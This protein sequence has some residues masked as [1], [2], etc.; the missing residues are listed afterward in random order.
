MHKRYI[1]LLFFLLTLFVVL[2]P[3]TNAQSVRFP[4]P[5]L[6]YCE[7]PISCYRYCE[8]PQNT[9]TCWSYGKYVLKRNV[10]GEETESP[11]QRAK[12]AGITFPVAELGGCE[13]AKACMSY[14]NVPEHFETCSQFAQKHGL[15]K[16]EEG[17][18]TPNPQV[19]QAATQ[20]LGCTSAA[21]CKATCTKQE[22]RT[23]CAEFAEK[24][25]LAKP[26]G[27]ATQSIIAKAKVELGCSS[28]TS[29]RTLCANPENQEK[30]MAFGQKVALIDKEK[31]QK[32]Q[33]NQ[34]HQTQQLEEIQKELGCTSRD[35]CREFCQKEE[36][37]E[38][39][40]STVKK[41]ELKED[42][43][44]QNQDNMS[45]DTRPKPSRM[46]EEDSSERE[47]ENPKLQEGNQREKGQ[48]EG[49][50]TEAEC[51]AICEKNPEKCPGFPKKSIQQTTS[52]SG[53]TIKQGEN[54]KKIP[55]RKPE[56]KQ[57]NNKNQ[58]KPPEKLKENSTD[59]TTND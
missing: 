19:L 17:Q 23:K 28:E 25:G 38:K 29:C 56:E 45:D 41:S 57:G 53:E 14:C 2:P 39:C 12:K 49:C 37:R 1:F 40:T 32:Y 43:R 24:Y 42:D 33:E 10:L 26:Q 7:D 35:S 15:E 31:Y 51:R 22:N 21:Q 9:A 4:I 20:E 18:N 36:N 50:K 3:K 8:A 34:K 48:I 59:N 11:D 52:G 16:K 47:L 6:G 5:E 27:V 44:L 55:S 58:Q 13:N 54:L 30:C 46:A